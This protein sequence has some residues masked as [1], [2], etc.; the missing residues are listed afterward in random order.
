MK[1][2]YY[3][4][5]LYC[6]FR[7]GKITSFFLNLEQEIFRSLSARGSLLSKVATVKS[8]SCP[9]SWLLFPLPANYNLMGLEQTKHYRSVKPSSHLQECAVAFL[10]RTHHLQTPDRL[11]QWPSNLSL[12][13][14]NCYH[15]SLIPTLTINCMAE[16]FKALDGQRG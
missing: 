14:L 10:R 5:M 6:V 8:T 12:P 15:L 9:I 2:V 7:S 4:L 13:G 1:A 3:F 16:H 11:E